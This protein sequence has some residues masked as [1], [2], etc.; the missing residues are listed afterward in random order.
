MEDTRANYEKRRGLLRRG[1]AGEEPLELPE[2][3][4][5]SETLDQ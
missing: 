4:P 3:E 5:D 1:G 2:L